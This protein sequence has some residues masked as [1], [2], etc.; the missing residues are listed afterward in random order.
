MLTYYADEV[1]IQQAFQA[2]ALRYLPK[3]DESSDILVGLRAVCEGERT[4]SASLA[5]T[6]SRL[7]MVP[8]SSDPL[9]GLTRRERKVFGMIVASSS[10]RK[11]GEN[12]GI[13]I[14]T[15]EVY[16]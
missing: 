6:W 2:R 16:R 11:V 12:L 13:S 4:V 10:N 1:Y 8:P 14:R 5:E 7:Q 9:E 15:V 3:S